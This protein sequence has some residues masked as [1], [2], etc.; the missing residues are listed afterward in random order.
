[1]LDGFRKHE[2]MPLTERLKSV[3]GIFGLHWG[4]EPHYQVIYSENEMELRRYDPLMVAETP[5][6]A[7]AYH[8]LTDYLFGRNDRNQSLEMTIPTY[9]DLGPDLQP[10]PLQRVHPR[11]DAKLSFI[12]PLYLGRQDLPN[13]SDPSLR[14]R[15]WPP[16]VVACIRFSGAADTEK[17]AEQTGKLMHWMKSLH[18][19]ADHLRLAQYDGPTTIPFLRK[20]EIQIVVKSV[21]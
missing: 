3:V 1:M 17:I 4:A 18:V 2:W 5:L 12:L 13:P 10:L 20:N 14:L 6:D 11:G 7:E 8:R 16:Q 19:S 9:R 21:H 15:Q